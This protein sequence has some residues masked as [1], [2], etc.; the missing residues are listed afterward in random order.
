MM[1]ALGWIHLF[2]SPEF[3]LRAGLY[4][5]G[6]FVLHLGLLLRYSDWVMLLTT[7][8]WCLLGAW[9]VLECRTNKNMIELSGKEQDRWAAGSSGGSFFVG[10]GTVVALL[11]S[12]EVSLHCPAQGNEIVAG[13]NGIVDSST[14]A[15]GRAAGGHTY[16]I[17][18]ATL[19]LGQSVIDGAMTRDNEFKQATEGC[20]LG[21]ALGVIS[22]VLMCTSFLFYIMNHYEL[23]MV[24]MDS[25]HQAEKKVMLLSGHLTSKDERQEVEFGETAIPNE[26][27]SSGP[28]S[29]VETAIFDSDLG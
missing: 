2:R 9:F 1:D 23:L 8:G 7:P 20:W 27:T 12:A 18:N 26:R 22:L 21:F 14:N 13:A 16:D 4:G 29:D 25:Q 5:A 10:L 19:V 11:S 3:A 17:G 28:K 15:A 6:I 24:H